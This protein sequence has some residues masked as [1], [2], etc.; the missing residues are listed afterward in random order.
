MKAPHTRPN[1]IFCLSRMQILAALL[2]KHIKGIKLEEKI[3]EVKPINS[4]LEKKIFKYKKTILQTNFFMIN[5]CNHVVLNYMVKYDW[6][7]KAQFHNRFKSNNYNNFL[8]YPCGR[9]LILWMHKTTWLKI[10]KSFSNYWLRLTIPLL[11]RNIPSSVQRWL[12]VCWANGK[13]GYE[14]WL[15]TKG[16]RDKI[17]KTPQVPCSLWGTL[18]PGKSKVMPPL[19]ASVSFLIF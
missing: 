18:T 12:T 16:D 2:H 4:V 13:S 6:K 10:W 5:P 19:G 17:V 9:P 15:R 11:V 14:T 8:W 3:K 1:K 7:S